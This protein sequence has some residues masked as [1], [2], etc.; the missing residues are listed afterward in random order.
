MTDEKRT[1]TLNTWAWGPCRLVLRETDPTDKVTMGYVA[2][3][4]SGKTVK[5]AIWKGGKWLDSRLKDFP[6]PVAKSYS[7][8][9]A[10]GTPIF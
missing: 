8:E 6:A 10:D 3:E 9:K 5:L 7:V 1:F 4:G 2:L